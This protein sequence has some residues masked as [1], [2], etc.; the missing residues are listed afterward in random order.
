MSTVT[1]PRRWFDEP[2]RRARTVNGRYTENH[3]ELDR[4]V[5]EGVI[6][7]LPLFSQLEHPNNISGLSLKKRSLLDFLFTL[8]SSVGRTKFT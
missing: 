2:N 7:L 1:Y 6:I 3:N 8:K 5:V 4:H